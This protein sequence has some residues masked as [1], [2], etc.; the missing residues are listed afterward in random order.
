[1]VTTLG[2][3]RLGNSACQCVKAVLNS[4]T[5]CASMAGENKESAAADTSLTYRSSTKSCRRFRKNGVWG[6]PM[7]MILMQKRGRKSG[8]SRRRR[9]NAAVSLVLRNAHKARSKR[10]TRSTKGF[11]E[12]G[13]G[14]RCASSLHAVPA[15]KKRQGR[16]PLGQRA[17]S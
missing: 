14:R 12:A 15:N 1:M 17:L 7:L 11:S 8:Y 3:V 5:L 13:S 4:S 9:L 6:P 16:L 2:T 10:A